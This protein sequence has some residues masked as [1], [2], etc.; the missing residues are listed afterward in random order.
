MSRSTRT[1]LVVALS[2][3]VAGAA[4]FMVYRAVLRI[5]VREVEVRSYYVAVA[6]KSL[7]IAVPRDAIGTKSLSRSRSVCD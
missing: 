3:V 6:S 1:I 4:S 7:P 5:P 2:L